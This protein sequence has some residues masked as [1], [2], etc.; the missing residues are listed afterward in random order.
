M[1]PNDRN[2]PRRDVRR[3]QGQPGGRGSGQARPPQPRPQ[4]IPAGRPLRAVQPGAHTVA[5]EQHHPAPTVYIQIA[6][7]LAAITGAEVAVY[8]V[9]IGRSLLV[10]LLLLLSALK[11]SLVVAFYMH[12]RFDSKVFRNLFAFGLFVAATI[13]VALILI[14]SYRG[15]IPVPGLV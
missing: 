15:A 6:V 7:V 9:G 2:R 10:P 13:M 12:L 3:V 1:S 11:F 5:L 14:N 8:Y 4:S